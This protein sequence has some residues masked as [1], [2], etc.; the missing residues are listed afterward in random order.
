M[1]DYELKM[2]QANIEEGYDTFVSHVAEG[3]KMTK[4]QVDEIGQ[5]RVWS[6]ENAKEIGLIDDFGGLNDAIK[7]AAEI[8][9]LDEYRTVSLPALPDPFEEFFKMGS[10]NIRAKF[11]KNEL[12]EKYRYYEYFKKMSGLNG[13]YARMPYDIFIN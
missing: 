4:E 6:G 8:V 9:G 7:L 1:T 2:M 3:R 5:G 13:I 12:G 10:D 11:M